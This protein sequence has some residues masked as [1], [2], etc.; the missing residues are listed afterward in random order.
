MM[1]TKK[2]SKRWE[3][4]KISKRIFM[5]PSYMGLVYNPMRKLLAHCT[6]TKPNKTKTYPKFIYCT[7]YIYIYIYD[8]YLKK[9]SLEKST[10][11]KVH[12]LLET[13]KSMPAFFMLIIII[14]SLFCSWESSLKPTGGNWD[15]ACNS[16]T[17]A[18]WR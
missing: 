3:D 11:T 6:S 18:L 15:R 17:V 16:Y 8:V 14:F 5:G 13:Y 7:I 1:K 12:L 9:V 4:P 10:K 2:Q